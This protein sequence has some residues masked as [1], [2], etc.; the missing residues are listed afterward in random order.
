MVS[1][2]SSSDYYLLTLK[3]SI[4]VKQTLVYVHINRITVNLRRVFIYKSTRTGAKNW[5]EKMSSSI[6]RFQR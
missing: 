5:G 3:I 4:T 6:S 1:W 2:L